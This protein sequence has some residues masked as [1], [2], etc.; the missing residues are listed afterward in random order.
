ML[1]LFADSSVFLQCHALGELRWQE[2]T[3]E[4]QIVVLIPRAVQKELDKHKQ[5]GNARRAKRAR[6]A[7]TLFRQIVD[8]ADMTVEVAQL[9]VSVRLCFS[10]T[11]PASH[12]ELDLRE[13]DDQIVGEALAYQSEHLE[14]DIRVLTDD[15]HLMRTAKRCAVPYVA[16]PDT[17]LLPPEPDES[18]K[19]VAALE[20]RIRILEQDGPVLTIVADEAAA[21]ERLEAKGIKYQ[22]LTDREIDLLVAESQKIFPNIDPHRLKQLPLGIGDQ[23]PSTKEIYHYRDTKYPK[24]LEQLRTSLQD[25]H[26]KLNAVENVGILAF[27]LR[28]EGTAPAEQVIVDF[29][30][31]GFSFAPM[32]WLKSDLKIAALSEILPKRP[33]RPKVRRFNVVPLAPPVLNDR[34]VSPIGRRD[35]YEFYPREGEGEQMGRTVSFEC[36][37]FRHQHDP[38]QLMLGVIPGRQ[39]GSHGVVHVRVGAR[40]LRAPVLHDQPIAFNYRDGDTLQVAEMLIRTSKHVSQK[41]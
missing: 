26:N 41:L 28:N 2:I 30:C 5:Q 15:T 9:P 4:R 33:T 38:Q 27:T 25:L 12:P 40:N 8:S 34:F 17:W 20:Q 7:T 19:A 21:N 11:K 14:D 1:T 32:D 29:T 39:L 24:W 3:T 13:S 22:P 10:E 37:E 16:I 18:A 6:A 35:Q 23:P 31:E 36:E